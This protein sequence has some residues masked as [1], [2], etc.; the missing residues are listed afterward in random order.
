[1]KKKRKG[2]RIVLMVLALVVILAGALYAYVYIDKNPSIPASDSGGQ[3]TVVCVGDSITYGSGA[4]F[5]E[6]REVSYVRE[7]ADL[8]GDEYQVLNFGLSGRTASKDGD[9]PYW[10]NKY[11]TASQEAGPD[12]VIIMLGTNDSK[13]YNW[14]ERSFTE[15][16]TE[17]VQLYQTLPGNPAVY[18]AT[19]PAAFIREGKTEV[20]WDIDKDVIAEQIRPAVLAVAEATGA[21]C[22]DMYA[23]TEN[24]PELFSDGV[25][26]N[27]Q[28]NKFFART[29]FDVIKAD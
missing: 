14:N 11:L 22:I 23:A 2:I 29:I 15:S 19:P 26:P 1:M 13:A 6:T 12:I 4:F 16:L 9:S 24:R 10:N 5:R 17:L 28:G 8:L 21:I 18:L 25:H 7:L 3:Y 27:A 20:V